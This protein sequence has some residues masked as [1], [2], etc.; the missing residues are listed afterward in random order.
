MDGNTYSFNVLLI[1]GT[2][3]KLYDD[4]DEHFLPL[5][6]NNSSTTLTSTKNPSYKK[7]TT[8]HE[9]LSKDEMVI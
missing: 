7:P 3:A 5:K 2:K 6:A 4:D 8:V 1:Q 9:T